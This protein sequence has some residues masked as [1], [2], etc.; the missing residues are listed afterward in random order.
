[1]EQGTAGERGTACSDVCHGV[2]QYG[3]YAGIRECPAPVTMQWKK[4]G[5]FPCTGP[6]LVRRRYRNRFVDAHDLHLERLYRCGF[7]GSPERKDIH[8]LIRGGEDVTPFHLR[9]L[10]VHLVR[11]EPGNL[12]RAA[13]DDTVGVQLRLVALFKGKGCLVEVDFEVPAGVLVEVDT[14]ACSGMPRRPG[15]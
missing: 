14:Q 15:W 12:E 13:L 10:E 7:G 3:R 1:M 5:K 6:S 8:S 9:G 2:G 11:F 4:K